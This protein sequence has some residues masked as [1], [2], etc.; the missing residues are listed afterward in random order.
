MA[1]GKYSIAGYVFATGF[2]LVLYCVQAEPCRY[3]LAPGAKLKI[4]A[5]H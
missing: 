5:P 3:D 4:F 1:A 2:A